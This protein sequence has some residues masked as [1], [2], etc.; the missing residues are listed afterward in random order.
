M[1]NVAEYYYN[2]LAESKAPGRVLLS[3]VRELFKIGEGTQHLK[4]LNRLVKLYGKYKVYFA[5]LTVAEFDGVD[6]KRSV[7]PLLST[8]IKKDLLS[9]H[10]VNPNTLV[11]DKTIEIN[12]IKKEVEKYK[13]REIIWEYPL[14]E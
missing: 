1:E 5:I 8:I 12:K 14:N 11:E 9:K 6:F 10:H 7:F 2:K 13:D 3:M 4:D